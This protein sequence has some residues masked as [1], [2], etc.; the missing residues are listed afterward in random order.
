MANKKTGFSRYTGGRNYGDLA[1]SEMEIAQSTQQDQET[2]PK[3]SVW[4]RIGRRIRDVVDANTEEDKKKRLAIGGK[5][6]YK[7]NELFDKQEKDRI[8]KGEYTDKEKQIRKQ[9][10]KDVGGIDLD[11]I[12]QDAKLVPSGVTLD[13]AQYGAGDAKKNKQLESE[14]KKY[15][16]EKKDTSVLGRVRKGFTRGAV[17]QLADLPSNSLKLA[18]NYLESGVGAND[19]IEAISNPV[20]QLKLAG[21]IALKK[22]GVDK[23]LGQKLREKGTET[24][25]TIETGLK[26]NPT[27]TVEDNTVISN[28]SQGAGNLGLSTSMSLAGLGG[29]NAAMQGIN[30]A[31][32]EAENARQAGKS[33]DQALGIG[34]L[35]GGVQ[36]ALEKYGMD[37]FIKAGKGARKPIVDFLVGAISEGAQEGAQS[38]SQSLLQ[39]TY[40][41]VDT[42]EAVKQ[43]G[44]EALYGSI[45]GGGANISLQLTSNM[46]DQGIPQK[47]AESIAN[48]VV[49]E[50]SKK[51]SQTATEYY[52]SDKDVQDF[53][54]LGRVPTNLEAQG[55]Y[56][57]TLK[58]PAKDG[59]ITADNV[60]DL[61]SVQATPTDVQAPVDA[62]QSNNGQAINGDEIVA[63]LKKEDLPVDGDKIV[64]ALNTPE[65]TDSSTG[66]KKT[67]VEPIIPKKETTKK[68][69]KKDIGTPFYVDKK[70]PVL[71]EKDNEYQYESYKTAV[72]MTEQDAKDRAVDLIKPYVERGDSD[73]DIRYGQMGATTSGGSVSIGGYV[74]GKKISSDK[75]VVEL[76]DGRTYVFPYNDIKSAI[77]GEKPRPKGSLKPL[78][79]PTTQ[80]AKADKKVDAKPTLKK[81]LEKKTKPDVKIAVEKKST[82]RIV[83]ESNPAG[84]L[85]Q[86]KSKPLNDTQLGKAVTSLKVGGKLPILKNVLYTGKDVVYTDLDNTIVLHTNTERPTALVDNTY[87]KAKGIDGGYKYASENEK[88]N[89]NVEDFPEITAV[90]KKDYKEAISIDPD[91]A[92]LIAEIL[93]HVSSDST[94]DVLQQVNIKVSNGVAKIAATDSYTLAVREF[95]TEA[96]DGEYNISG[97]ML[98]NAQRLKLDGYKI[99][100]SSDAANVSD[101]DI[102]VYSQKLDRPYPPYEKLTPTTFKQ[103]L[104]LDSDKLKDFIKS[105]KSL[106]KAGHIR[107]AYDNLDVVLTGYNS[108]NQKIDATK[109]PLLATELPIHKNYNLQMPIR[110]DNKDVNLSIKLFERSLSSIKNK[111]VMRLG[112]SVS[113]VMFHEATDNPS[114]YGATSKATKKDKAL[115]PKTQPIETAKTENLTTDSKKYAGESKYQEANMYHATD[116]LFTKFDEKY[117]GDNTGAINTD[118]GFFFTDNLDDTKSFLKSIKNGFGREVGR[119]T[120]DFKVYQTLL[121]KD[122]FLNINKITTKEAELL[123]EFLGTEDG[124]LLK[125]E[126]ALDYVNAQM[127]DMNFKAEAIYDNANDFKDFLKSKG[128]IGIIDN[129]GSGK[130]EYVVTDTKAIGVLKEINKYM[131]S[132]NGDTVSSVDRDRALSLAKKILG[133]SVSINFVDSIHTP[134]GIKAYGVFKD[135]MI[136]FANKITRTTYGHEF[137]HYLKENVIDDTK[138]DKFKKI[139]GVED[140]FQAEEDFADK[141]GEYVAN[142]TGGW[143][144]SLKQWFRDLSNSIKRIAGKDNELQTFFAKAYGGKYANI[145]NDLT[146]SPAYQKSKKLTDDPTYK[147]YVKSIDSLE[148][149]L[150]DLKKLYKQSKDPYYKSQ[151][152]DTQSE[153]KRT[154]SAMTKYAK[155]PRYQLATDEKTEVTPVNEMLE[156]ARSNQKR[157]QGINLDRLNLTE[158]GRTE[159]ERTINN[160]TPELEK[161]AGKK[162]S[163][164]EIIEAA[165]QAKLLDKVVS[166]DQVKNLAASITQLRQMVTAEANDKGVSEDFIKHL[167]TLRSYA[168]EAGRLLQSFKIQADPLLLESDAG[169]LKQ[170]M[171]DNLIKAGKSAD[172]II[173]KAEGVDFSNYNEA[174]EF[175][176][177]LNK[178]KLGDLITE[179]R[180]INM[181]SSPKTHI[182]NAYTNLLQAIFVNPATKLYASV[183]D[184]TASV[185]P[186]Q[187]REHYIAEIPAFY[188]G[189]INSLPQSAE[190]FIRVMKGEQ[191]VTQ[192][193]LNRVPTNNTILKKAYFITRLLEGMDVFFGNAIIEGEKASLSVK[194]EKNGEKLSDSVLTRLATDKAAYSVFR[195]KLDPKNKSGQGDLLSGI[196][197]V[198]TGLLNMRDNKVVGWFVPF[199]MTPANILKQG[200]EYSPTGFLTLKGSTR[201]KEQT[202][203]AL[204]GSTVFMMA[205]LLALIGDATWEAPKDEEEKKAFYASGRKPYSIKIGDK[206]IGYNNIGPLGYPVAL[207]SAIKYNFEDSKTAKTDA[208]YEK[209]QST[210]AG[211]GQY[212]TDQS[213]L[214]GLNDLIKTARGEQNAASGLTANTGRQLIPLSSLQSWVARII[215]PIERDPESLEDKIK[216]GVPIASKDV[217]P[218]YDPLGRPAKRQS[219]VANALLPYN[220][221]SDS[222]NDFDR[223]Y[224]SHIVINQMQRSKVNKEITALVNDNKL[225]E[226]RKKALQF[227]KELKQRLN[228]VGNGVMTPLVKEEYEKTLISTDL[229]SLKR[230]R[231]DEDK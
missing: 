201:K 219:P 45:L 131:K 16:S 11:K 20:G 170:D 188:R 224:K 155:S 172:E 177:S 210:I 123:V 112:D 167:T 103:N 88:L 67:P 207:A 133:N 138:W 76:K 57:I 213:Y 36:A 105:V 104:I 39:K 113:A 97:A 61:V 157:L 148:G 110:S 2:A 226:A 9:F 208:W 220:V 151:I 100:V 221:S 68:L 48:D 178:A 193:D 132:Q 117:L 180:Y 109:L 75:I 166:R 107:I 46:M 194:A 156:R 83:K 145:K 184:K 81:R 173:K 135:D 62:P 78:K 58:E 199:V 225:V 136:T 186:N 55:T 84:K 139:I 32:E 26:Y 175:Y 51:K 94:R 96:K 152:R 115:K 147:R 42:K 202:A 174:V 134:E 7:E 49:A 171:I 114:E 126:D 144:L 182:V 223:L 60:V 214:K 10:F 63:E 130:N 27:T 72:T 159:L 6:D 212:T 154:Q 8:K 77:T 4:S 53:Q 69:T 52:L 163:N 200:I 17:Q 211:L 158:E 129:F 119:D 189:L 150:R 90:T 215:D 74:N 209:V 195:G 30:V 38:I 124:A 66:D 216:A 181:L 15:L 98:A 179:Y 183:I 121:D 198:T 56:K 92:K 205:G 118:L 87:I 204:V 111:V 196:D 43:A 14:F 165:K 91:S 122:K 95:K 89:N 125:S 44:L 47:E 169:K 99:N 197:K 73:K 12:E 29:A 187:K 176:R 143:R 18:G 185:L 86:L 190:K 54:D 128:Y 40:K 71:T 140:D 28:L 34:I 33:A 80:Q 231:K 141:M 35:Q 65:K 21:K 120:S 93:V 22:A 217:Q 229:S 3:T 5:A 127:E 106:D 64:E 85:R 206:W 19:V 37:E 191:S 164:A 101:K 153:I 116:K 70:A 227:N 230:R 102:D 228:E 218:I 168:S 50:V 1:L 25:S 160:I 146:T 142:K 161:I 31:G 149:N 137:A 23:Q 79:R 41:N 59:M 192:L 162:L 24:K 222:Q 82:K 203:K 108:D 13:S